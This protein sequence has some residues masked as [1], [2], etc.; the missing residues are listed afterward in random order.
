[1][2]YCFIQSEFLLKFEERNII[3]LEENIISFNNNFLTWLL[4]HTCLE[5]IFG[6]T[7]KPPNDIYIILILMKKAFIW[8]IF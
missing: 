6:P 5:D 8:D 4:S 3:S 1:M 2:S 7:S